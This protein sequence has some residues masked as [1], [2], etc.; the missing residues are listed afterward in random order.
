M[1]SIDKTGDPVILGDASGI[2]DS[3]SR[4]S[5]YQTWFRPVHRW[6]RALG[7]PGIDA[8]DLT[9][10]SSSSCSASSVGS[11]VQTS[12]AGCIA[13][14]SSR[15][16]I[17]GGGRGSATS[18]CDRAMSFST[19]TVHGTTQSLAHHAQAAEGFVRGPVPR[20]R[21]GR[22]RRCQDIIDGTPP[23]AAPPTHHRAPTEDF[24]NTKIRITRQSR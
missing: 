10:R 22:R 3:Q 16:A 8:E 19:S 24:G 7:G 13:S 12:P 21:A 18:S 1:A 14:H 20:Y 23:C 6:I 11:T 17:T 15:Y 5:L 2:R 4:R 9:Q